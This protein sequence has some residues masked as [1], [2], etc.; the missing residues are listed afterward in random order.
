MMWKGKKKVCKGKMK[1]WKMLW[2]GVMWKMLWMKKVWKM[3]K[4]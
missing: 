4:M 3:L 2:I 1:V